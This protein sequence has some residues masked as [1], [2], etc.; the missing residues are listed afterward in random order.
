[1]WSTVYSFNLVEGF[2]LFIL[3]S[4]QGFLPVSEVTRDPTSLP[5]RSSY[6]YLDTSKTDGFRNQ[7]SL[8]QD[9]LGSSRPTPALETRNMQAGIAV[10]T[11][12]ATGNLPGFSPRRKWNGRSPD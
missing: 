12:A 10:L 4:V 7:S 3:Y 2:T 8:R 11:D 1:M 6:G 9:R 5:E